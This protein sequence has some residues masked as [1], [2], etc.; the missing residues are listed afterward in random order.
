MEENVILALNPQTKERLSFLL[1]S[2]YFHC[3]P[4]IVLLSHFKRRRAK[5]DNQ[6]RCINTGKAGPKQPVFSRDEGMHSEERNTVTQT[7]V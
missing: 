2:R 7:L 6:K 5:P 3:L 4:V 1:S